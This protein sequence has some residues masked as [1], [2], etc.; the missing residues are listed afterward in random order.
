MSQKEINST[1]Y[2]KR[3][4][5]GLCPRCGKPLDREGHYC[6]KCVKYVSEYVRKNREFYRKNN[7]CPICGKNELF[8]DEKSCPE[9]RAKQQNRR[10]N[11]TE[12][13]KQKYIY[14]FY[15]KNKKRKRLIYKECIEK[16]ICTKCGIR[17]SANGKR[18]CSICQEKENEYARNRRNKGIARSERP[19][20][21]LCYLCGEPLDREGGLCTKC[22]EKQTSHLPEIH[23]NKTWRNDNKLLSNN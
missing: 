10:D 17:K 1:L 7:L 4:E 8:G 20:Y 19:Q 21:N 6:S 23:D 5:N 18:K 3:K 22:A 9:C 14:K 16:G 13:Q 2:K 12:E 15:D 11:F